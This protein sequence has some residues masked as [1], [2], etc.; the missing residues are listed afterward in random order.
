MPN[1][2][3]HLLPAVLM[4]ALSPAMGRSQSGRPAL[5]S[6]LAALPAS[7]FKRVP[8]VVEVSAESGPSLAILPSADLL[9]QSVAERVR[10][11]MGAV[12]GPLAE[13]DSVVRWDQLAGQMVVIAHRDGTFSWA[14]DRTNTRPGETL[15]LDL[16][17]D[18]LKETAES[19]ER[20]FWPAGA[21]AD[22]LFFVLNLEYPLVRQD[23]KKSFRLTRMAFPLFTLPMPWM[24]AAEMTREP[25]IFYPDKRA[26][27]NG[28]VVIE[29]VVD[30][31]GKVE[32]KSIQEYRPH[33]VAVPTGE[34][35]EYYRAFRAATLRGVASGE[36]AASLVGGCPTRRPV[37]QSFEFKVRQ[38]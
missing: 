25:R 38:R 7:A 31:A 12:D 11:R 10:A 30:S 5:N 32:A 27:Y 36:Y 33:G 23:G 20:L 14:A 19:G 34:A 6:C 1:R 2:F 15:G 8:V 21:K 18:A 26:T 35:G 28:K 9:T 22:S 16:L 24:K 3:L 4:T 29:F 37:R 17:A 13:A